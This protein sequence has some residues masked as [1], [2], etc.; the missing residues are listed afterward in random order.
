M[1]MITTIL[2]DNDN[3]DNDDNDH[4]AGCLRSQ[5]LHLKREGFGGSLIK[6]MIWRRKIWWGRQAGGVYDDQDD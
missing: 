6:R 5:V 2:Q 3:D 1:M 4:F